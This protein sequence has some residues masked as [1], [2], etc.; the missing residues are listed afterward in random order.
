MKKTIVFITIFTILFSSSTVLANNTQEHYN[1]VLS[2]EEAKRLTLEN[3]NEKKEFEILIEQLETGIKL[4]EEKK[5]DLKDI[6]SDMEEFNNDLEE[7]LN[8]TS[9]NLNRKENELKNQL[10]NMK[11]IDILEEK[12]DE[13][14]KENKEDNEDKEDKELGI[15]DDMSYAYDLSLEIVELRAREKLLIEAVEAGEKVEDNETIDDLILEVEKT[16]MEL[17]QKR[18]LA[19]HKWENIGQELIMFRTEVIYIGMLAL[20]EMIEVKK[21]TMELVDLLIEEEKVKFENGMSTQIMVDVKKFEKSQL[22]REIKGLE[23]SYEQLKM[24]LLRSIGLEVHQNVKL[25]D[26]DTEVDKYRNEFVSLTKAFNY[27][28]N[29]Y[30]KEKELEFK[31]ENSN[32]V[33]KNFGEES[34]EYKMSVLEKDMAKLNL[35]KVKTDTQVAVKTSMDNFQEGYMDLLLA[36]EGLELQKEALRGAKIQEDLGMNTSIDILEATLEKSEVESMEKLAEYQFYLFERELELVEKGI[37]LE[38]G[39]ANLKDKM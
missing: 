4:A 11:T 21:N 25:Q 23:N 27:G 17:E 13:E 33:K 18:Y 35:E 16:I 30:L 29:V 9:S 39:M 26:I 7:E 6:K 5:Q 8:R 24:E 31:E 2:L 34:N 28:T 10:N 36:N 3:A 19:I 38:P 15:K 37:L 22:D 14:K 12:E 1:L 20:E 32:W